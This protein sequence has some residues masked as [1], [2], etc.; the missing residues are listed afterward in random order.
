MMKIKLTDLNP[1]FVSHGGEGVTN[2]KTG[3]PVPYSDKIGIGFDCPC[4]CGER[5]FIPFINPVH[6]AA[7]IETENHTWQRTGDT[8]ETMTLEPSIQRMGKCR[9]HGY[10]TNGELVSC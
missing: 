10:L 2:S 1:R 6:G 4:S 8:F 9:W 7:P 3:E 5:T